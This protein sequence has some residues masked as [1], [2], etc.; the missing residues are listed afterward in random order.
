M[1]SYDHSGIIIMKNEKSV[2]P[3]TEMKAG[4]ANWTQ[5]VAQDKRTGTPQE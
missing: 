4:L 2:S 1:R 3:G 5:A